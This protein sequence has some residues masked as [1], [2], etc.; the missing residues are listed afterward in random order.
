MKVVTTIKG[1]ELPRK[2]TRYISG[3]YYKIG[4]NKIENSGDC[5]LINDKYYRADTGYIIYDHRNKEYAVAN[6]EQF[7][8]KGVIDFNDKD[9]PI[10][11]GFSIRNDT[12]I[13]EI[14]INTKYYILLN[15]EIVKKT[16][17]YL[18]CLKNGKYYNRYSLPSHIFAKA[19]PCDHNLK[20]TL[21]YDSRTILK[22]RMQIFDNVSENKEIS[23]T[24]AKWTPYLKNLS[25][26]LEFE[27]S[28]GFVPDRICKKLGLIPL[29]DGSIGG[30]EYVTIPHKEE[31][32]VQSL[33]ESLEELSK[34]TEY[35]D[36][37]SLHLHI[38]N[39]PRTEEFILALF[40][41]L[42]FMQDD[43]FSMFPLYK[44]Y[45]FG[46]K[47]KHYTKP[48]DLNKTLFLMDSEIN[49]TNI[50]S[51]FNVLFEELSGGLSYS[52]YNNDLNEIRNHP[53]DP[54]GNSKWNIKSRYMSINLIPLIFGNKE[55]VEFRIHTPTYDVDKVM[56]HLFICSSL[57]NYARKYQ[58]NI[59]KSSR[60]L[61]NV[62]FLNILR[63]LELPSSLI[64][65]L[66]RYIKER[67][68][69]VYNKNADSNIHFKEDEFISYNK[70]HWIDNKY[71]SKVLNYRDLSFIN[72]IPQFF[73]EAQPRAIINPRGNRGIVDELIE[74]LEEDVQNEVEQFIRV[75]DNDNF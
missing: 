53:S 74:Q 1:E 5:Y 28:K 27:T 18:E 67:Q 35:D 6:K 51:N 62:N 41:L 48:F 34:R 11:G 10:F 65:P 20:N 19:Q 75:D 50:K 54:Q 26:G 16:S 47:R 3:N 61:R 29:R 73:E 22:S 44:K 37:C 66:H 63:G 23:K 13:I 25:F 31:K 21:N 56:F 57:I 8:S 42:C 4:D 55:T 9:E 14:V 46:Y 40:K 49:S 58:N 38:G 17:L 7:I 71:N 68:D 32:G 59:L 72:E 43:I 39:I 12:D 52:S 69:F 2:Q 30:L 45:N 70:I 60:F 36:K 33:I 64:E 24:V 15:E